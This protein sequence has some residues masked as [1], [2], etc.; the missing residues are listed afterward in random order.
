MNHR[1]KKGDTV[2]LPA[3]VRGSASSKAAETQV[4]FI[5]NTESEKTISIDKHY[6][7][8]RLIEDITDVQALNSL[9]PFYTDDAGYALATQVDNDLFTQAKN[10]QG[11]NSANNWDAAVI[12]GDGTTAWD[13]SASTNTGNGSALADAG[14]RN[15]I[16]TLDD[17]DVP[18][19]SRVLVVP[20]VTKNTIIGI[21]RFVLWNNVGEAA[22]ANTIR[23]GKLGDI[24]GMEVYV[25]TNCPTIQAADTTTNY[26]VGLMLHKAAIAL[27]EQLG[28]RV[29][30][31]YILEY[32]SDAMVADM[33]YGVGE[34]RDEAGIAFVVPA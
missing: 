16:Q 7:Y 25:S 11:G 24:Y 33:I 8:A 31:D 22:S 1:G 18:M 27:V 15:M 12:G 4:T 30:T 34:L 14:I 19:D 23:N 26:R 13:P 29:Q 9:R 2:H 6:H 20:P 32:L 3:P 21:D 10:L 5:A 17:D 28:V